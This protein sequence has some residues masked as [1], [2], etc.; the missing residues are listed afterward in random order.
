MSLPDLTEPLKKADPDVV[1]TLGLTK[2]SRSKTWARRIVLLLVLVG[3]GFAVVQGVRKMRARPAPTF[4]YAES[5]RQ[6]VTV[7]VTATGTLRA[8]NTVD[9]GTEVSGRV[10]SVNVNFN[11]RV[12]RGQ[13]LVELDPE[14][15]RAR[16]NEA[17]ANLSLAR[18]AVQQAQATVAEATQT[19]ARVERL[20]AQHIAS[21]A[22]LDTARAT[23]ARAEA[24]LLSARAQERVAQANLSS[25]QTQLAKSVIHS[26]IDGV[27][28]NRAV[29]PGQTVNG[30]FQT[31]VLLTLAEDITRME[32]HVDIDE[33]DIG[34]V[35]EGQ[36]ATFTVAAYAERTFESRLVELRNAP[37]SVQNVVSY[38]GVLLVD[39]QER[40]LRP[41]MTCTVSIVSDRHDDVLV[42]PNAALRFVP[43]D[44]DMEEERKRLGTQHHVWV[45]RNGRPTPIAVVTGVTDGRFTEV[46]SGDIRPG[47]QLIV[48][49]PRAP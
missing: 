26:P 17:V 24:S 20:A 15:L 5:R 47:Q 28:L 11:D 16:V 8:V 2:G 42:V 30:A 37:R 13:V 29:E 39:N 4:T 46:R 34:R 48:D 49:A 27:V 45:V 9:V 6:D 44:R 14:Q 18:A 23:R 32:L 38:E 25:A 12:T 35:H 40:L 33:A 7:V 3:V 22:D 1:R 41:G 36:A 43:M 21:D 10:Q 31:P 19:G